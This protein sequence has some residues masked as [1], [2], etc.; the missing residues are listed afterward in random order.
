LE[1]N[2]KKFEIFTILPDRHRKAERRWTK[3]KKWFSAGHLNQDIGVIKSSSSLCP[4]F[5]G[6][7]KSS[8]H[9]FP[10]FL[11]IEQQKNILFIEKP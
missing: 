10:G 1:K 6:L 3:R 9:F 7:T 8:L 5:P 11:F 2:S 4:S